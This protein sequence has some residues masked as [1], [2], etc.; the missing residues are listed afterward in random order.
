[1]PLVSNPLATSALLWKKLRMMVLTCPGLEE[2]GDLS[3]KPSTYHFPCLWDSQWLTVGTLRLVILKN[4][5]SLSYSPT[6]QSTHRLFNIYLLRVCMCT[7]VGGC[8]RATVHTWWSGDNFSGP[9]LCWTRIFLVSAALLHSPNCV[10]HKLR[11]CQ[12]SWLPLSSCHRTSGTAAMHHY[13]W[14][15]CG[16]GIQVWLSSFSLLEYS[17]T[18]M[19]F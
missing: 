14:T 8:V 15:L 1:M 13:I 7:Y 6:D 19:S 16:L 9:Y 11:Q 12:F 17:L 18:K 2:W 4:K 10:A 3:M 5:T